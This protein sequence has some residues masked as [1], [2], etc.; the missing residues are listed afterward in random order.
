MSVARFAVT[1]RVSVAMLS[2]A[3]VVLG[4]FAAPRLAV[5]LLPSF[6]PPVVTVSVSYANAS[7][8]TIETSV[9]RPI[10][11]AVSRVSGI[12]ILESNSF[13]GQSTVRVQF[14]FGTDIN[15]AAVDVQQQIARIRASLPNDPALQEPQ[16]IK[17]DPNAT[18]V[19]V[20][21]VTDSARSQRD[22]SDLMVNELS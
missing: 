9:T 2:A 21:E 17:A 10:E 3:I 12:D 8:E 14:N 7:P 13:Q 4:L 5:A 6:A 16:V 15:V 19:L 1:R 11:N 18:P 22:L 20:L